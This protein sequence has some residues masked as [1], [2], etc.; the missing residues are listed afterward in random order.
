MRSGRLSC[1]S[2]DL[3]LSACLLFLPGRTAPPSLFSSFVSQENLCSM[4]HAPASS[5][6]PSPWP[7]ARPA[8]RW[9]TKQNP[10]AAWKAFWRWPKRETRNTPACAMRRKPPASASRRLAHCPI[11]SCASNSKTSPK[12][13]SRTRRCC[14]AGS[15][16]PATPSCKTCRGS[17]N[18]TLNATLPRLKL[19]A[20]KG[21]RWATGP[22]CRRASRPAM[23]SFITS[24]RTNA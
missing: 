7:R 10:A 3:R 11:P 8:L 16:A 9:Q 4:P 15:E 2:E 18:A 13:A 14:Q 24:G 12:W 6:S 1:R 23:R 21:V 19:K 20:P 5:R 17:A 22:N